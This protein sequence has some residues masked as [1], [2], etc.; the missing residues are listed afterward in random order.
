M[1]TILYF[2]IIYN[3]GLASGFF[4]KRIKSPKGYLSVVRERGVHIIVHEET[5]NMHNKVVVVTYNCYKS[6]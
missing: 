4:A 2:I 6:A 5:K 1:L 3:T